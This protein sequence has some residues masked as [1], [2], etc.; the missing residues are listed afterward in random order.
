MTSHV[1]YVGCFVPGCTNNNK[2]TPE[3]LLFNVPTGELRK[4]WL[5]A[6]QTSSN[7]SLTSNRKCC[8]DHFNVSTCDI[9]HLLIGN[10][11]C[12]LTECLVFIY[13]AFSRLFHSPFVRIPKDSAQMKVAFL[14]PIL[15][16]V[17]LHETI[18]ELAQFYGSACVFLSYFAA[19]VFPSNPISK[20]GKHCKNSDIIIS[21]AGLSRSRMFVVTVLLLFWEM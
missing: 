1:K 16:Y 10:I 8:E 11:H 21:K 20:L 4:K 5:A 18:S 19:K 6:V 14:V 9:T 7:L 12:Y 15:I 2:S 3:K 17:F 13:G